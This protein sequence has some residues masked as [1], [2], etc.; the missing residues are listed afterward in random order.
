MLHAIEISPEE[1]K[2]QGAP[3]DIQHLALI[4]KAAI[5]SDPNIRNVDQASTLQLAE[6]INK[7]VTRHAGQS[8]V[9]FAL[10]K[11]ELANLAL[12]TT[13]IASQDI[14]DHFPDLKTIGDE[15]VNALDHAV[16]QIRNSAIPAPTA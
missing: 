10:K 5:G 8:V 14:E 7:L 11:S 12:I 13:A 1:V 4:L 9:V 2:I 3:E 15:R 6:K 16:W